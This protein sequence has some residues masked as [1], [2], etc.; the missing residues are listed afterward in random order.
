MRAAQPGLGSTIALADTAGVVQ[1]SYSYEPFGK[2]TVSGT[3]NSNPFRFTGREEDGATGLYFFRARYLN[4]TFGRFISEDPIGFAGG[5]PNLYAY[6]GNGPTYRTDPLGLLLTPGGGDA[7]AES[8]SG[9]ELGNETRS[10]RRVR[11]P[12]HNP[13]YVGEADGVGEP[14]DEL[15]R[16]YREHGARLWRAVLAFTGDREVASDA[17]AEA[18]AQALSVLIGV[19]RRA[20]RSPLSPSGFLQQR[21]RAAGGQLPPG[22]T[23]QGDLP[24]PPRSPARAHGPQGHA[25]AGDDGL[26]TTHPTLHVGAPAPTAVACP[27]ATQ[28]TGSFISAVRTMA[29][30]WRCS[31]ADPCSPAPTAAPWRNPAPP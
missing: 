31:T 19:A 30:A 28:L 17:V 23:V 20:L 16:V 21:R 9:R 6:V 1:T 12:G 3:S 14:G 8:T 5:D 4:P 22:T 24:E 18:F 27:G 2:A 15:E 7:T 11:V 10:G 13:P 29:S 25:R 26:S